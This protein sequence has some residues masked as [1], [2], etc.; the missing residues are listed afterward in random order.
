MT[1]R[2]QGQ[3]PS[4]LIDVFYF[5][6]GVGADEGTPYDEGWYYMLRWEGFDQA[7]TPPCG[8]YESQDD[9]V[10]AGNIGWAD[11]DHLPEKHEIN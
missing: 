2:I 3:E 6:D 8:P 1:I 11:G 4:P 9:A 10:I 5:E 7:D